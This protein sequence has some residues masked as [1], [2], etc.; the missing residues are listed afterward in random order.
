MTNFQPKT[1]AKNTKGPGKTVFR[2]KVSIRIRLN[3]T[4]ILELL[5]RKFYITMVN[6]LRVL[7]E[8]AYNTQ[9]RREM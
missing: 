6:I 2:G 4:Q 7:M 5:E 1:F 9:E 8:K 3:L